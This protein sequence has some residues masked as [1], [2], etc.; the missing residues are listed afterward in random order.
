MQVPESIGPGSAVP[1]TVTVGGVTS[2]AS[3]TL[4]VQ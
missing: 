2:Q 1:I 4:A 3:V